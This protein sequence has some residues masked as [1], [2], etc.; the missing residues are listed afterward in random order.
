LNFPIVFAN[1]WGALALLGVPAVIAIHCLQQKS[2]KLSVSTLFLLERLA[3]DS[4]E[5][6]SLT[7]LRSS[8]AFWLQLLCVLLLTWLLV[9][10]RWLE[11]NFVQRVTLVLDSS[12]SMRAF[13]D[14]IVA[15]TSP[16]L[17][18]LAS[19]APRTY[20]TV[21]ETDPT[22]PTLYEGFDLAA[23]DNK[24]QS[25]KPSLPA[26]DPT[27]ALELARS[28]AP[29]DALVIFVT[30]RPHEIPSGTDLLAIG[31]PIENCGL[32]GCKLSGSGDDL[33]WQVMVQNYGKKSAHRAWW[34]EIAGQKTQ[35]QSVDLEPG[36]PQV[37]KG[38][39]PRGI[40][41]LEVCLEPDRFSL[42]DRM[43][44][45]RPKPKEMTVDLLSDDSTVDLF[46][47]LAQ[48]IP[49]LATVQ[50][51]EQADIAFRALDPHIP[52]PGNAVSSVTVFN[53]PDDHDGFT[54]GPFAMEDDPLNLDLNWQALGVQLLD[55]TPVTPQD[56]VLL[57][58]GQKPVI[59]V[60]TLAGDR[61][62]LVFNFNFST[63]NASRLPA[64]V[65]LV[66]RFVESVRQD[67]LAPETRNAELAEPLLVTTDPT[68]GAVIV[69]G[70]DGN[71]AKLE[72]A[73]LSSLS[74]PSVPGFFTV[75]Q[76]DET[77][78]T[79]AAQF[80]D[81]RESDF[82]TATTEDTLASH[83]ARLVDLQTRADA[84]A[85]L[86]LVALGALLVSS[87]AATTSRRTA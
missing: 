70:S 51:G 4:K 49:S 26:H 72:A 43:A 63:S 52:V 29:R 69:H 13:S 31:E 64:F 82:S 74:A 35:E 62:E 87:W 56:H 42:D 60:R 59:F 68:K 33:H 53:S 57:W 45:V 84:W 86:W 1:P 47:K 83:A 10:P 8:L 11:K 41:R 58:K 71:E 55:T 20:W 46:T 37:L 39:F 77:L 65:L 44:I 5:G 81:A 17:R 30:D 25:W 19:L 28:L 54:G 40:D 80:A 67:K 79:G 2:R 61:R 15:R 66:S 24:L 36:H 22:K 18:A 14:E 78:L 3:P 75:T 16:R 34:M 73:S 32:V 85:P 21:I 9:E 50:P 27:H 7:W 48:T 12:L 38:I 76:G 23:L 6:R